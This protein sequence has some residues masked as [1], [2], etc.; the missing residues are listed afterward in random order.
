MFGKPALR[1]GLQDG[2]GPGFWGLG[3]GQDWDG[4]EISLAAGIIGM[5]LDRDFMD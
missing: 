1:Q 3:D 2:F 5:V 4:R